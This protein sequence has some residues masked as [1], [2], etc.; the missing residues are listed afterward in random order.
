MLRRS[1]LRV[2][3]GLLTLSAPVLV[4]CSP[5]FLPDATPTPVP[6]VPFTEVR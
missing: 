1:L 5:D 6:L 4:S 3:G 2:V